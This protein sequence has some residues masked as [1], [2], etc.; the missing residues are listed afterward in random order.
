MTMHVSDRNRRDAYVVRLAL[1]VLVL[2]LGCDGPATPPT[3]RQKPAAHL[4]SEAL[5]SRQIVTSNAPLDSRP[6]DIDEL[7]AGGEFQKAESEVQRRLLQSPVDPLLLFWMGRIKGAQGKLAEAIEV[8]DAIPESQAEAYLAASGQTAQWCEMLEQWDQAVLRYRRVLDRVLHADIALRPL[9]RI[10]NRQGRRI[11]AAPLVVELCRQ[12]NI[13]EEELRSLITWSHAFASDDPAN[14]FVAIGPLGHARISF[15]N[16]EYELVVRQLPTAVMR[17]DAGTYALYGRALA[18]LQDWPNWATWNANPVPG[19]TKHADYWHAKGLQALLAG[20][21][22]SGDVYFSEAIMLDPTDHTAYVRYSEALARVD[23]PDASRQAFR[24]AEL[25]KKTNEIGVDFA[26]DH[27]DGDRFAKLAELLDRLDRPY[28]ALAWRAVALAYAR[29]TLAPAQYSQLSRELVNRRQSLDRTQSDAPETM[30]LAGLTR[31]ELRNRFKMDSRVDQQQPP[32]VA[33]K[34]DRELKPMSIYNVANDVNLRHLYNNENASSPST[35]G[36]L[37]EMGCGVA[38]TDYDLDG[39]PDIY[40]PQGAATPM[41]QD[42]H[43]PNLLYRN[44][45]GRFSDVTAPSSADDRS[46][47]QGITAGDLNQDGFPDLCIGNVGRNHLLINNG[48][49]TFTKTA[50]GAADSLP[51]WTSSLAIGDLSGDHLPEIVEINYLDDPAAFEQH[52]SPTQFRPA[53]DRIHFSKAHGEYLTMNLGDEPSSGLGVVLA[54][55]DADGRNNIFIAN[56]GRPDRWWEPVNLDEEATQDCVTVPKDSV[57]QTDMR[58]GLCERAIAR[59][60]AVGFQ[61]LAGASMGIA[62]DDFNDDGRFDLFVTQ[63]YREPDVFYLQTE[64]GVFVDRTVQVGTYKP[65]L[66]VLGFGTQAID[67]D[68]D[69]YVEIAVV[70]GHTARSSNAKI[71][72]EMLPQIYR[73]GLEGAYAIEQI[74]DPSGYWQTP[75][76]GRGL[77]TLDWNRDGQMDLVA[78][79]LVSPTALLENRTHGDSRW[80]QIR[81][82][83]TLSERDAIGAKV[84]VKADEVVRYKLVTSG[85]GYG[86]KNEAIL[87]VGLAD[88]KKA[89]IKVQWPSGQSSTHTIPELDRRWLIIEGEEEVFEDRVVIKRGSSR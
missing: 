11:E 37:Q 30:L 24:R 13:E 42:G 73:R 23:M 39:W 18:L 48:D 49:G 61:G 70:N 32:T 66:D 1:V 79:H 67:L 54:D 21:A 76:L 71:P 59:G 35:H 8:L 27:R 75:A 68:N 3:A 56:D 34:L 9:A 17:R 4:T 15:S 84:T 82:V 47:T 38:V 5:L 58:L 25:L 89:E 60:C 78:T 51:L 44:L 10:L 2:C 55:L 16:A 80:L 26:R 63:F 86:S 57:P 64:N 28:E 41:R 31:E 22:Q 65:S 7:F 14:A 6:L 77:A 52:L 62:V 29:D 81:V 33:K 12:G 46:F 19:C 69:G 20:D 87:H 85:D 83:G 53:V 50:L 40:L 88:A 36:I 45:A 74:K 72:Y 43:Q